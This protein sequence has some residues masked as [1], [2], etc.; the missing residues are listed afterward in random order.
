MNEVSFITELIANVGAVG[1]I[2]W[3]VWHVFKVLLPK[4]DA[5]FT[6]AL[7]RRDAEFTAALTNVQADNR[8]ENDRLVASL[9]GVE[10]GLGEL[11]A[12]VERQTRL[13]IAH[14]SSHTRSTE[15]LA[16]L[17]GVRT[18]IVEAVA[19]RAAREAR[20]SSADDTQEIV[21]RVLSSLPGDPLGDPSPG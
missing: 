3:L 8:R 15:E 21:S 13:L 2:F 10:K 19:R 6:T 4:R 14:D 12:Q 11:A 18:E 17:A 7:E 16:N 5:D 20:A 9:S 1:V